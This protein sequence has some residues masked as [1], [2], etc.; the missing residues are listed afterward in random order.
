M[1]AKD[2]EGRSACSKNR[3]TCRSGCYLDAPE[4]ELD[5]PPRPV[6][7]PLSASGWV[8]RDGRGDLRKVPFVCGW[9]LTGFNSTKQDSVRHRRVSPR[10][11]AGL[12]TKHFTITGYVSTSL[13]P[14]SNVI[15]GVRQA[16][17]HFDARYGQPGKG[18]T[19]HTRCCT[20][21][22]ALSYACK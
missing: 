16:V 15:A 4:A 10:R 2:S 14:D 5:P 21:K 1:A 8:P 3:T 17:S 13:L 12:P 6:L 20:N 11:G 22:T 7:T 18:K 9:T 19:C